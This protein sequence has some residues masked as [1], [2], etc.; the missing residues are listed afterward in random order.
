[1]ADVVGGSIVW[2]EVQMSR[3]RDMSDRIAGKAPPG[4]KRSSRWAAV[5]D[6][7][8]RGQR[9]SV[10]GGR[11]NLVAHHVIPFHLAPD[12]ELEHSNLIALCEAKRYGINCHLLLGH[13]GNWRRANPVILADVAYWHQRIIEDR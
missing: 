12:L 6:A 9:C 1:M 3:W 10:C 5:R 13:I 4:A 11:R 8:L 2:P 7:F